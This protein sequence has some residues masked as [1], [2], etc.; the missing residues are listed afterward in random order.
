[1]N[2]LL[3]LLEGLAL[4][5]G[6]TVEHLWAVLLRQAPISAVTDLIQYGLIVW[7]AVFW[8]KITKTIVKKVNDRDLDDINYAWVGGGW[9]FIAIFVTAA[10]FSFPMSITKVINPEYWATMEI[11]DSINPKQ[12]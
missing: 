5:L 3:P 11:L 7:V 9:L 10:F 4:S 6:T 2:E 1:M 12:N 8:T